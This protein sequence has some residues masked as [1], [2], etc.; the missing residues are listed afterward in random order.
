MIPKM[1]TRRKN[2]IYV[3]CYNHTPKISIVQ[4]FE[5]PSWWIE[6][7][8]SSDEKTLFSEAR[9]QLANNAFLV[10]ELLAQGY[11]IIPIDSIDYPK[12]LKSNLKYGAPCVIFTKGNIQLL[13]KDA[14][15]I[16]GSRKADELSLLFTK[17]V[18]CEQVANNRVIVSGFAKGVD[19]HALDSAIEMNGESIIVLPQ[20][21][22]TFGSGFKQYYRQ[23]I[24]GKVLVISTFHPKSPW[25]K[26]HAMARNPI[27][28]GMANEIYVA[29][30]DKKGGTWSGA[31]DGLNKGREIFVRKPQIGEINANMLLIQQGAKAVDMNGVVVNEGNV[32]VPTENGVENYEQIIKRCLA[33]GSKTSKEILFEI[34]ASWTDAKMKRYLRQLSYV[35]EFKIRNKI[36]FRLKG[37]TT[38]SLFD[39]V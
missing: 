17:N 5:N 23:I 3:K 33:F 7:G 8:L 26:E 28:Y 31:I 2:E 19:R 36:Y 13:K 25:S 21:I 15:A 9:D 6:F 22:T 24:Q 32:P 35:E 12:T 29:Q 16:V 30:S 18:S 38:P 20:G 37:S 27:I 10:E 11:G 34:K 4:L 39:N 14:V 1:W